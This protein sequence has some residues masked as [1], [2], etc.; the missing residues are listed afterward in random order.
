MRAPAKVFERRPVTRPE[1]DQVLGAGQP[2]ERITGSGRAPCESSRAAAP[3]PSWCGSAAGVTSRSASDNR[4]RVSNRSSCT[5]RRASAGTARRTGGPCYSC[6]KP[7]VANQVVIYPGP[8][9]PRLRRQPLID[10]RLERVQLGRHPPPAIGRLRARLQV[11]LHRPPIPTQQPA[12]SRVRE[13][14]TRSALMSIKS[15]SLIT[16]DLPLDDTK[17][18]ERQ[19]PPRTEPTRIR[20][21]V[22]R[23]RELKGLVAHP[24]LLGPSTRVYSPSS[25]SQVDRH[26]SMAIDLHFSVDTGTPRSGSSTS[27]SDDACGRSAGRSGSARA[28]SCASCERQDIPEHDARRWAFSR[29]GYWR[30]AGSPVLATAL[31][32]AYWANLGLQG[33]L[34]SLPPFPGC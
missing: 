5:R 14:L 10:Q 31:P 22:R 18:V 2:A 12:D 21:S 11:P 7:V 28:P 25:D 6:P 24:G 23:G 16:D 33:I 9:Q 26:N 15:S 27:G 30:I 3:A 8:Q 13:P 20:S 4:V 19:G 32:N 29:K 1:G 34:R 17:V